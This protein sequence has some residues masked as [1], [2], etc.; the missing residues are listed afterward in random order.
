MVGQNV[1]VSGP[2]FSG[3]LRIAIA[4]VFLD[5]GSEACTADHP[6]VPLGIEPRIEVEVLTTDGKAQTADDP[7][8]EA[9]A[10]WQEH[11]VRAVHGG[12]ERGS[13]HVADGIGD[14][15]D[16]AALLVLVP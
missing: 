7:R 3:F 2:S 16:L 12:G 14:G 11:H 6:A 13:D 5:V 1:P 10:P 8:E 9:K 15:E 4:D